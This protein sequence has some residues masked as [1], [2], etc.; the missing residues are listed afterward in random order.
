[1]YLFFL[2]V[3]TKT[4]L[5]NIHLVA[6]SRSNKQRHCL[7]KGKLETGR[8][9]FPLE[10][11]KITINLIETPSNV[12]GRQLYTIYPQE[13]NRALEVVMHGL[14]FQTTALVFILPVLRILSVPILIM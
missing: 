5:C 14:I 3:C 11:K 7:E 9:I 6:F 4:Y 2:F 13:I 10:K 8:S 12:H 1:M